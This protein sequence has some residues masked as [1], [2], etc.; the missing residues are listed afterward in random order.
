MYIISCGLYSCTIFLSYLLTAASQVGWMLKALSQHIKMG[1]DQRIEAFRIFDES[2]LG[3]HGVSWILPIN[4]RLER[5]FSKCQPLA[6]NEL[7]NIAN[8]YDV[9]GYHDQ[10]PFSQCASQQLKSLNVSLHFHNSVWHAYSTQPGK[11]ERW[12]ING[13]EKVNGKGRTEQNNTSFYKT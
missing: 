2:A 12:E 11:M 8:I 7:S 10:L 1:D 9:W 4:S 5:L 3:P 6:E 13:R